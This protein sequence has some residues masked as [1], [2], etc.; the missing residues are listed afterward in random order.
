VHEKSTP[1]KGEAAVKP[2]ALGSYLQAGQNRHDRQFRCLRQKSNEKKYEGGI[3]G[4]RE[5]DNGGLKNWGKAGK[6]D[7]NMKRPNQ[8]RS[9][10]DGEALH[11]FK[12]AAVRQVRNERAGKSEPWSVSNEEIDL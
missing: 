4:T 11:L 12:I 8:K 1:N 5:K 9:Q 7:K 3:V 2:S 6:D 10:R